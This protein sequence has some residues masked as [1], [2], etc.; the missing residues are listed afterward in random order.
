MPYFGGVY[1]Y[2][3]AERVQKEL[4]S[5][6]AIQMRFPYACILGDHMVACVIHGIAWGTIKCW[7]EV[8]EHEHGWR[9][10]YAKLTSIDG[11]IGCV[12]LP[13]LRSKYNV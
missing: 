10:Q 4:G 1:S 7:G 9:A 8:V 3:T 12:D 2:F 6:D 11:A 5:I 13:C